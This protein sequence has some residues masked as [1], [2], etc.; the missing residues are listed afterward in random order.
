MADFEEELQRATERLE[1]A[2][3]HRDLMI[4]KAS[5]AGMTRKRVAESSGLSPGRI[6]Q[7]LDARREG[8]R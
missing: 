1:A 7:I 6:Q 8:K 4:V 2:R 5:E 3:K